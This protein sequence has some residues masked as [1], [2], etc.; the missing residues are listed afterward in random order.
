VNGFQRTAAK[1][2]LLV[3]PLMR[4]PGLGSVL[5]RSMTVLSYTGRKSGKRFELPVSYRRDGETVV[6]GVAMPD[7]KGWWRNFSGD[8]APISL[9][10][11]GE[12]RTGHAISSR[13]AKGGV[14]VRIALDQA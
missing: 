10:L 2:N 14:A 6:V 1:F 3:T 11:D 5:S 12:T 8:G 13:D 4:L 9:T 7:K